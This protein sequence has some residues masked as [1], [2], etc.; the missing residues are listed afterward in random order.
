MIEFINLDIPAKT[1][2][3]IIDTN[4]LGLLGEDSEENQILA[5]DKIFDEYYEVSGNSKIRSVM[6]KNFKMIMLKLK[7]RKIKDCIHALMYVIPFEC[8]DEKKTIKISLNH[9]GVNYD[10]SKNTIDE[11]HR[12]LKSDIGILKN[13]LNFLLSSIPKHKDSIKRTF[14]DDLS[15]IMKVLGFSLPSDLTMYMYL[16]HLKTVKSISESSNKKQK[17]GK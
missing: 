11:C 8:I 7:I 1:F 15:A 13:Q 17:N 14:E 12:I 6:E 4:N 3:K 2:F 5:W 16:S 9:L 10:I